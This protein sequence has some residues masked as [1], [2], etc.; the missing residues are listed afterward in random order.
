MA[1]LSVMSETPE[2]IVL[3][4]GGLNSPGS[5]VGMIVFAIIACVGLGMFFEEG[6]GFNP[7]VLVI[8]LIIVIGLLGTITNAVRSTR[9]VIDANQR[10]AT[11][12]DDF[13]FMPIGRQEMAF[14]ALREVQLNTARKLSRSMNSSLMAWQVELGGTD[15]S[16]MLVDDRGGR[17]EMQA[18]AEKIGTITRRPVRDVTTATVTAAAVTAPAAQTK[19][20]RRSASPDAP[21]L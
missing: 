21:Y 5:W 4:K 17:A 7:I 20:A 3:G 19:T 1:N 13:L 6:G 10:L 14:N 11:R 2:R 18:L 15:G 9:V 8:G 16:R 12:S